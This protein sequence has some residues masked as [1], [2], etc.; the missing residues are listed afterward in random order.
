MLPLSP[1]RITE[2]Y[3]RAL[4]LQNEGKLE[5][6]LKVYSTVL[7]ANPRIAEAHYQVGR[8]FQAAQRI[9]KAV[10]HFD[11]AS[12]IK[13]GE[14]AIWN[15]LADSLLVLDDQKK[16]SDFLKAVESAGLPAR[17]ADAL[18]AKLN[19][20]ASRTKT[21][22]GSARAKE[23]ERLISLLRS[24]RFADAEKLGLRLQAKH[25]KV[26]IIADILACAQVSLQKPDAAIANFKKAIALDPKYAEAH[27]NYGRLLFELG[28]TEEAIAEIEKALELAPS[29]PLA[30]NNMGA[31]LVRNDNADGAEPY[32]RKAL[33][34]DPNLA[35]AHFRLAHLH[36]SKKRHEEAVKGFRTGIEKGY[37]KPE[38]YVFLGRSLAAL[39]K[40][41]E[42]MIEFEKAIEL[43]PRNG[44]AHFQKAV[45]LQSRGDFVNAEIFS[46]KAIELDPD[47]GDDY[48][49]FVVSNTLKPGDP[50]IDVM[51]EKFNDPAT[52]DYNRKSFGFALAKAMEDTGQYD[53]VFKY[54]DEANRIARAERP[55]DIATR[56]T[57]IA[58]VKRAFEGVRLEEFG[59]VGYPDYAP[60][61]VTGMPRS[62]TTLVEQIIASHSTVT[63]AGEVGRLSKQSYKRLFNKNQTVR[64][65]RDFARKEFRD[66][67][68]D[69]ADF[70]RKRLPGADRVSDKSIQTYT[71]LGLV[72]LALPNSRIVVVR[73]DPRDNLLSIYKNMF[74]DGTHLY[75][76]NLRDL[77][78]YYKLFADLIEFWRDLT[79]ESFHEIHYEDLIASPEEESRKLI[80]ACGLDW[81]EQ[82]LNFHQ[83]KRRVETL[84][85]YQVRQP[86]YKSS[87]KG[88]QRYEDELRELFEALE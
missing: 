78:L 37:V 88:W 6:A 51:M 70:M 62:G 1:A 83:N 32:F 2:L 73:R 72:K 64:S 63:G 68:R 47:S 25:R 22:I 35:E 85:V 66:L 45:L 61:F 9:D 65:V 31:A 4:G 49:A 10:F 18:V 20:G 59:D 17:Q 58:N 34:R 86:I 81:E 56:E 7:N 41:D 12:K 43:D 39:G 82:C 52:T 77:G 27:N 21:A 29:M 71:F 55:Y 19:N 60:I 53:R 33:Q 75:A 48:R 11:L 15:A 28:R 76:Y 23:I 36:F 50:L 8:I 79:P 69:Y 54:L 67:G 26:A 42:A 38:A 14:V 46:R 30:L 5:E 3:R 44:A 24:N 13:P 40:D 87:L 80:A 84:S 57:E 74:V 16:N